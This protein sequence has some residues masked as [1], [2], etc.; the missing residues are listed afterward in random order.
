MLQQGQ[1]EPARQAYLLAVYADPSFVRSYYALATVYQARG[2]I[3]KARQAYQTFIELW[4]GDPDFLRQA[5]NKLA[6]L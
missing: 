4:Q 3:A 5:R 2:E 6:R 1:L